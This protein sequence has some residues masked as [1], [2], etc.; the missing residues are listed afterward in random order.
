MVQEIKTIPRIIKEEIKKNIKKQKVLVLYG[1]RQVGKTTLLGEIIK[2]IKEDY[3]FLQG[4]DRIVRQWMESQSIKILK[5]S[6]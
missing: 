2:E 3:L 6:I 4:E 5:K 1:A